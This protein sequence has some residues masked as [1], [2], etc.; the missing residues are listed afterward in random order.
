[1][2]RGGASLTDVLLARRAHREL[3][4]ERIDLDA[5]AYGAMLKIRQAAALYPQPEAA[6]P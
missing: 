5:A 6:Q 1:M 4:L 3:S 2:R